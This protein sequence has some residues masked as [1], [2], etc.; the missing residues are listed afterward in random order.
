VVG[1]TDDIYLDIHC[2]IH[3][4]RFKT[5]RDISTTKHRLILNSFVPYNAIVVITTMA[6]SSRS[7]SPRHSFSRYSGILPTAMFLAG[8]LLGHFHGRF[9][10][11]SES[12]PIRAVL[13]STTTTA[14]ATIAPQ[15]GTPSGI[16]PST[17]PST[18]NGWHSV[19]VFYGESDLF[20]QR[21]PA[22]Q[23]WFSQ[24]G[25]DELIVGLLNGK[26]NGYFIDLAANDAVSLSNTYSLERFYDWKGLCIEP[27]PDYWYNLTF[28]DCQVV[29]AVVGQKRMEQVHFR[30]Q[31][32]DHGGIA[33]A[34]FDNGK[35][36]QKE[37]LLTYTVTLQEILSRTQAPIEIDYLSLDVEGA[38]LFV[39]KNF[40]LGRYKIKLITAERLRGEARSYLE[41]NGYV[42]LSRLTKWGEGLYAHESVMRDLNMS[43]LERYTV[44][45]K[46]KTSKK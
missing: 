22:D 31:A 24:A 16:S 29:G 33:G 13:R 25:Q 43:A 37:S 39:L 5:P 20:E 8:C 4:F 14:T 32:G 18:E 42:F 46:Q 6:P 28:R 10:A 34:G 41:A 12:E 11:T 27:N 15:S 40:P 1:W 2:W 19:Q 26:T 38:E 45:Q 44:A 3:H 17:N 36:W 21:L 35:R 30:F 23:K 9:A 7:S